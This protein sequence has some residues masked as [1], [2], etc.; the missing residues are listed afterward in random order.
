MLSLDELRELI[1]AIED[2]EIELD[3]LEDHHEASNNCETCD[4]I[5]KDLTDTQKELA[6]EEK[7][8]RE[9]LNR[10]IVLKEQNDDLVT[11]I[12]ATK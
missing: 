10:I 12:I 1:E 6:R 3:L 5:K 8:H 4:D 9:A 7:E 2:P 11:R